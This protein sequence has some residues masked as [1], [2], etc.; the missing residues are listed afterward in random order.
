MIFIEI[1]WIGARLRARSY[2]MDERL[3]RLKQVVEVTKLS[4]STIWRWVKDGMFPQPIKIT[5]RVTVW[6]NSDIQI[7]IANMD[8]S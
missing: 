2:Q 1:M 7:Y 4:K 8:K 3:L 6:K 5:M